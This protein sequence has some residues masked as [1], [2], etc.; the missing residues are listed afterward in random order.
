MVVPNL[1]D[2]YLFMLYC[3]K[4]DKYVHDRGNKV[5]YKKYFKVMFINIINFGFEIN[6]Q[7]YIFSILLLIEI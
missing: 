7:Y 1:I 4:A 5:C 6:I 2:Y 3:F